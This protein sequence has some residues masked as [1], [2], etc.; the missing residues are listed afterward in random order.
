MKVALFGATGF[1]GSYILDSLVERG[2]TPS[3]LIREK[4]KHKVIVPKNSKIV[5]GDID[6]L[7]AIQKTIE[8]SNAI[9]Y[10]VGIINVDSL[11]AKII[12][13]I[14]YCWL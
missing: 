11:I 5:F 7:N 8:G 4:S 3:V 14:V 12:M 10:N 2:Y 9:I 1:V 6:D 13:R